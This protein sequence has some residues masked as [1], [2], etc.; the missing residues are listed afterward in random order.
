[1]PLLQKVKLAIARRK[2]TSLNVKGEGNA[3]ELW[4]H[5]KIRKE[6]KESREFREAIGREELGEITRRDVREYQLHKFR[7][8]MAYT[9]ENSYYYRKKFEAAGIKP[10]DIRTWDDLEKVPFTDPADL[11]AEPLTFLAA[12]HGFTT[13]QMFEARLVLEVALAGLAAERTRQA[14]EKLIAI[15]D[16]TT[17]MFASLDDPPAFLQHEAAF[18]RALAVAAD[19]P[20]LASLLEMV[21]PATGELGQQATERPANLK[22]SAD[23]HRL[24]YQAVR[25]HDPARARDAMAAHLR[26]VQQEQAALAPPLPSDSPRDAPPGVPH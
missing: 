24:I 10:S 7:H 1:M 21:S 5:G 17:E 20:V 4:I 16:E 13:E 19:N 25:A 23:G 3:L 9:I 18:H 8:Q 26:R 14:P 12:L 11:A 6:F 2:L 22:G 15:S